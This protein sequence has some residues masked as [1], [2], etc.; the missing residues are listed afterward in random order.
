M[1]ELKRT[2]S[3][4]WLRTG[5]AAQNPHMAGHPF[6]FWTDKATLRTAFTEARAA[7]G[8]HDREQDL[9]SKSYDDFALLYPGHIV[10]G[11]TAAGIC[12][13]LAYNSLTN[14]SRTVM[15]NGVQW[16]KQLAREYDA[17][18]LRS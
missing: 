7:L 3:L 18:G 16:S 11:D 8:N 9:L 1:T 15:N 12:R 10:S 6:R 13:L 2:L 4:L 5:C 17:E 14:E